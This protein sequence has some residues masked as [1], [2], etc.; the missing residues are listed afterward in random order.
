MAS[1]NRVLLGY[2]AKPH[3]L[4]GHAVFVLPSGKDTHLKAGHQVWLQ[5]VDRSEL[6]K[7]GREFTIRE[8]KKGNDVLVLLDGIVD[9]TALEAI[10]P[11]EIFCE[12]SQFPALKA[13]EFYVTDLLGLTAVDETGKVIGKIRSY[14]ETP[15]QLIFTIALS[16]GGEVDLPYVK[17]FF[18]KVDLAAGTVQVLLPDVIE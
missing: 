17:H 13:G 10:L 8:I 15:A 1:S 6:P 9:R 12:R 4:K 11:F 5:P 7:D 2:S 3:G 18:P 16:S 14:F